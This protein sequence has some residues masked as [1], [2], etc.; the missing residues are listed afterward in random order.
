MFVY[1][2]GLLVPKRE[3]REIKKQTLVS[4]Q[5]DGKYKGNREGLIVNKMNHFFS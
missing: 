1:L 2:S 4:K 5:T 3:Q